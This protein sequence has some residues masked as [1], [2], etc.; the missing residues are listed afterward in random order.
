MSDKIRKNLQIMKL[1]RLDETDYKI[2]RILQKNSRTPFLEIAKTLGISNATVHDRVKKLLGTGVL[3]GFTV[4]LDSKKLGYEITA[5]VDVVL[6]HPSLDLYKL[7]EG[8]LSIPE[9]TEAYNL[10]GDTDLLLK[11]KTKTIDDLRSLL[12]TKIQHL[13]GVKR[14]STSIVLD[15]PV[16]R[17]IVV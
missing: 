4:Q 7:K 12:T 14:L 15:S 16:E 2:L 3:R 8:L 9:I 13:E 6:D 17:D 1:N 10:T 5:I 11:I